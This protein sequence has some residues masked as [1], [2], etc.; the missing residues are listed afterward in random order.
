MTDLV[1]HAIYG[2]LVAALDTLNRVPVQLDLGDREA[3]DMLLGDVRGYLGAIALL[4]ADDADAE[5][6]ARLL[7][8]ALIERPNRG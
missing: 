8:A 3:A 5:G 1:R 7:K 2:E 4:C 6:Y